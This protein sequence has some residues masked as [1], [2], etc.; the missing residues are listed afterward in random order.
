[1]TEKLDFLLPIK[2]LLF[3]MQAVEGG[4]SQYE[5]EPGRARWNQTHQ[6][7]TRDATHVFT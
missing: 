3:G 4:T 5:I 1:M 7:R 2:K 6:F